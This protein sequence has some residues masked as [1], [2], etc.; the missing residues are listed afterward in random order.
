MGQNDNLTGDGGVKLF[1]AKSAGKERAGTFNISI[2]SVFYSGVWFNTGKHT[3]FELCSAEA[4]YVLYNYISDFPQKTIN[5]Q[6]K[7]QQGM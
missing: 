1:T 7:L 6:I 4:H 3:C 2:T 5:I